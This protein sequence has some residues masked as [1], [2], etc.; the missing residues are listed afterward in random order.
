MIH[1]IKYLTT[2]FIMVFSMSFTT[3]NYNNIIGTYGVSDS[4]PSQIKLTINKEF[5]FSYQDFSNTKKPINVS[6][7]WKL[8]GNKIYLKNY[9]SHVKFHHI[10]SFDKQGNVAKSRQG[11][12]F[13]KLCKLHN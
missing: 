13:Y 5:T 7:T 1:S 9:N 6:G 10:W 2:I 3:Q 4:D 12:T 8:N 11:L